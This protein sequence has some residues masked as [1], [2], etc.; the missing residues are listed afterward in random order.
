MLVVRLV[1]RG[2]LEQSTLDL[3]KCALL[4]LSPLPRDTLPRQ[5]SEGG[6]HVGKHRD[7]PPVL[8]P[9]TDQTLHFCSTTGRLHLTDDTQIPIAEHSASVAVDAETPKL[10]DSKRDES[11][12][13]RQPHSPLD[14]RLEKD[15]EPLQKPLKSCRAHVRMIVEK[16]R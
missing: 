9:R 1:N 3:L 14:A 16:C 8:S 5:V 15:V 10:V 6:D 7:P 4:L 12:P 2:R 11:F 13:R